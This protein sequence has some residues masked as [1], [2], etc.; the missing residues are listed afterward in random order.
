MVSV[1]AKLSCLLTDVLNSYA[2][3]LKFIVA[4]FFNHKLF[5]DDAEVT[6]LYH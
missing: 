4:V 1:V 5:L 3:L 6:A 2:T